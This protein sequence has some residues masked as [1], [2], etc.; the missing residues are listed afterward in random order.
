VRTR[1][2][3]LRTHCRTT[4]VMGTWGTNDALASPVPARR[5]HANLPPTPR[6]R[7]PAQM[8][9]VTDWATAWQRPAMA[10]PSMLSWAHRLST[11]AAPWA[12]AST[13]VVA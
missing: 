9:V 12:C 6:G 10:S 2:S 1:A 5:T 13:C 3:W 11:R 4:S 8:A 7:R